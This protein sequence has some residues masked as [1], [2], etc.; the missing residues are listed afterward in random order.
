MSTRL[1]VPHAFLQLPSHARMQEKLHR[2]ALAARYGVRPPPIIN[3]GSPARFSYEPIP[4]H[5]SEPRSRVACVS[6]QIENDSDWAVPRVI[7]SAMPSVE[8]RLLNA[9]TKA[10]VLVTVIE[11]SC[12]YETLAF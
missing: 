5:T 4:R 11:Y 3:R 9:K 1:L 12:Y 10:K 2:L 8:A 6:G 7:R